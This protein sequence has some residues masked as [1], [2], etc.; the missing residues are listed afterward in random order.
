MALLFDEDYELLKNSGLVYAEDSDSRFLVV[1]NYPL[2]PGQYLYNGNPIETV[3]VLMIIPPN[4]NMDGGDMFWTHP[5][6]KRADGQPIPATMEF[7][8]GDARRFDGK[9]YCRWSRHFP[10]GTWKAK[11]DKLEKILSRIEWALRNP[12]AVA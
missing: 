7:G 4:Y 3:E 8:G 9:E 10:A 5:F 2:P 6:L 1:R 11:I 12:S